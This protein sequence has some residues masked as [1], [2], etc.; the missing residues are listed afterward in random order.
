MMNVRC[1]TMKMIRF[2][3][4]VSLLAAAVCGAATET[5]NWPQFRGPNAAGISPDRNLPVELSPTNNVC[6]KTVVPP[7]NSSPCI[8][9]DNIFLTAF[10]EK[11]RLVVL[12]VNRGDGRIRWERDVPAER[13]ESVHPTAGSPASATPATD[14]ERVYVFFG[15]VGVVCFGFDGRQVWKHALGPFT[16]TLGWGA[17]SSPIVYRDSVIQICDNDGESSLIALDKQTGRKKWRTPRPNIRAGYATPILWDADGQTQIVVGGS[18]RVCGYDADSGKEL[19]HVEQPKSF[20]ATTP[21]ASAQLLFAAGVDWSVAVSDFRSSEKPQKKPNWDMLFANHDGNRDGKV[22]HDEIPRMKKEAFDR[23]DTNHDGFLTREELDADFYR[24]Q[25]QPPPPTEPPPSATTQTGNVVMAIRPGGQDDATATHVA[26][27]VPSAAAYV[28]SPLLYENHL[29]VIKEGGILSCFDPATGKLLNRQRLAASGNYYASPVAADGK[30]Y[31]VS[32]KGKVTVLSAGPEPK[33]LSQSALDERCLATPAIA[34]GRLYVRTENNLFC[35]GSQRKQNDGI[36]L[37]LSVRSR[38]PDDDW[39]HIAT[40]YGLVMTLFSP[41]ARGKDLSGENDRVR[42]IKSLNPKLKLVVYGSAIN[43]AN[44]RLH[45]WRQPREHPAWF[46]KNEAGEWVTDWEYGG[47]LHL[48]P[49]N[50]EWQEFMAKAY[51]DY[52]SRYGYDGVFVDLVSSTTHYINFKKTSKTVNPKTGKAYTDAEWKAATLGLLRT[53]RR[54]IGDK[55]MIING[56]RGQKYFQTGYADF[57]AVADGMCNEGFT[58]WL[59]DPM[60]PRFVS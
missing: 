34:A 43:A 38:I 20:V 36:P 23:I 56:S 42:W 58:G 30:I 26:W 2:L 28:P 29:Y 12:C 13:I 19:W 8:W 10:V 60:K 7:G 15:S 51:D 4:A 45:A 54:H 5:E 9:G 25:K 32:E 57:L 55:L 41:T 31:I 17:A 52:L 35:F 39:R 1:R 24:Q 53:V 59:Q 21:V 27:R 18:G 22:S 37:C 16:Y 3:L 40:R 44:V 47:A 50:A 14:G 48:D 6:W 11:K 33:V 46:L 49:G